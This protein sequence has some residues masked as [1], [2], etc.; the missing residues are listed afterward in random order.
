MYEIIEIY[1][2]FVTY[3]SMLCYVDVPK[4]G[5]SNFQQGVIV[6]IPRKPRKHGSLKYLFYLVFV[7][8]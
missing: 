4:Y 6:I 7:S 8:K 1:A 5:D 3:M 2:N